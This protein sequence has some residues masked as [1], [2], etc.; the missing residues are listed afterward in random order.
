MGG[1]LYD[2]KSLVSRSARPERC[3]SIGRHRFLTWL[4]AYRSRHSKRRSLGALVTLAVALAGAPSLV[5]AAGNA[6]AHAA[7]NGVIGQPGQVAAY[8]SAGGAT[9]RPSVVASFTLA[10]GPIES[11][12]AG[13]AQW[14]CLTATKA[15]GEQ[16]RVDLL[17]VGYPPSRLRAAREGVKRYLLQ[18]GSSPAREYRNSVTGAA[19]LPALGGWDFLLPR[20]VHSSGTASAPWAEQVSYLGHRYVRESL[21]QGAPALPPAGAKIVLL[22]P[23]VLMGPESNRRQT[24]ETRR[25]DNSEYQYVN[26]T[27]DDYQTMAQAG[28]NCVQVDAQQAPWAEELGLYY[29]GG[30]A[31]VLKFPESLYNSQYLGPTMFLDEP[32]V[33]TR[34]YVLR[35]RLL[36]DPEFR[37]N[38]TPQ[39]AFEAFRGH[40]A[41]ALKGA[42]FELMRELA[43]K[44]DVDL[45]DMHFAQ[46]NLFSW[47]TM[48]ATADYE[49]SQDARVPA[50]FV[51]EPPGRIGTRRTLPEMDMTYG[52]QIRPD[53]PLDFTSI[54]FGFLRGAARAADKSWGISI[55]GQVQQEDSPWWLTH[56]YD[57]GATRFFFW[58]NAALA[59]VPFHEVLALARHLRTYADMHPRRGLSR[60]NRSAEVAIL[61]PAGYNLGHVYMG[62]GPLWGLHELNLERTNRDGVKYRTVMSNFFTEIERCLKLG[63]SFDLLWDLPG[64]NLDGYREVVRVREDGKV[65]VEA[66]GKSTLLAGPRVPPRAPGPPPELR[67]TLFPKPAD[68][69]L[70]I[71]ALA[72]VV[73]TSAP[74]YYTFGAAPDGIVYNE[75]VAWELYGPDVE[76]HEFLVPQDWAH[77][78]TPTATGGEARVKFKLTRPGAYRLRA[79]TVDTDGRTT[80]VWKSLLVNR[81]NPGVVS[82]K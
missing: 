74:V 69:G 44:P 47:E 49:L 11:T 60:L 33:G 24:D 37:R 26:L 40:Y 55:Y 54:I 8:R 36:K 39:A 16:F 62:R 27:R 3:I 59:A 43:S 31:A 13:K 53:D 66:G 17:S 9:L 68:G 78:A 4:P 64:V 79:A 38:I 2:G 15:N 57:L 35:P 22:R 63:E 46:E 77:A 10:L 6:R 20:P 45:G 80:V 81:E 65:Q 50:A 72:D 51:F 82:T 71:S 5:A 70:E 7:A 34:D 32:A 29:W 52:V 58:D 23:D 18:E 41:E 56:A 48:V 61:L 75:M 30:G 25:Y 21:T 67:I 76:D 28:I 73:E 1:V 42:P 14:I 19:V 12:S